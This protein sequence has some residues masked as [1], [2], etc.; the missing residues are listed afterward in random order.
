MRESRDT[1]GLAHGA[2]GARLFYG[3]FGRLSDVPMPRDAGD[4]R[5][6]DRRV[7][8]AINSMPERTRFMKGIFAWVGFRR[9]ACHI[10]SSRAARAPAAG[11]RAACSISP[12][13]V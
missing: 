8:D 10:P 6:L 12:S 11:A 13:T 7:V 5:L 4:Y 9:P 2:C 1:D 3:I